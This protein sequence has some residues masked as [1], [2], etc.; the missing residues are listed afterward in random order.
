MYKLLIR[1]EEETCEEVGPL[2]VPKPPEEVIVIFLGEKDCEELVT[3][4]SES[5][6]DHR[7]FG[8]RFYKMAF[9][10]PILSK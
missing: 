4:I 5:D 3:S 8:C 10:L 6:R 7:S 2:M 1:Y 9:L